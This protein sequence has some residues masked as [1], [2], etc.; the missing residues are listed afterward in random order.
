[1]TWKSWLFMTKKIWPFDQWVNVR[2][3]K[4]RHLTYKEHYAESTFRSFIEKDFELFLVYN[5]VQILYITSKKTVN[6]SK[7]I[8]PQ[9]DLYIFK[10][11]LFRSYIRVFP[12]SCLPNLCR[13]V[14]PPPSSECPGYDT[15]QSDEEASVMLELCRIRSTPSSPSL[16]GPLWFGVVGF[17]RVLCMDRTELN[18]VLLLNWIVWNR[19]VLTLKLRTYTKLNYLK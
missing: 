12:A 7:W 9:K 6:I 11:C 16:P 1:M 19:T 17:D 13:G 14:R 10:N 18:C 5:E 4:Q 3:F 2:F 15:K 8:V